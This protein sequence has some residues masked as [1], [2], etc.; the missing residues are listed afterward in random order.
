MEIFSSSKPKGVD[1]CVAVLEV[2]C[3]GGRYPAEGHKSQPVALVAQ[4]AGSRRRG[5]AAFVCR[6]LGAG[7]WWPTTSTESHQQL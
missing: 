4:P 3:G 5:K 2:V 7:S 6:D 1:V